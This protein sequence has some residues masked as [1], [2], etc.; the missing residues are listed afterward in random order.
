M[1]AADQRSGPVG[2]RSLTALLL[3]L[4]LCA[5]AGNSLLNRAALAENTID[6]ASFTAIR[7]VS[8]ALLLGLL[9]GWR[10]GRAV[11]PRRDTIVPAVALFLYAVS[12]SFAYV[13]LDAAIGALI[14][15]P[16]GQL[17]LQMIGIVR[18]IY[19]TAI[20][21]AGLLLA[22]AGLAVFLAP[23]DTAPPLA[24]GLIMA[25]AGIS[26]GFYSWAGK[27]AARPALATARNFV[28]AAVLCLLLIPVLGSGEHVQPTG[29]MLAIISGTITSGLGYITWY[30]VLPRLSVSTAAASQLSVPAIAA[31][32]GVLL[33]GEILTTRFFI[34]SAM[35]FAGIGLTMI[36]WSGFKPR[37]QSL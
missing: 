18:G 21:W 33:L 11:L 17:S 8:G 32:G 30:A 10:H 34:G 19:P 13:S 3:V 12:F 7:I 27:G 23:G 20:Q 28:G 6:W 1:S 15:F 4:T 37:Q 31:L 36:K 2:G 35:I 22:I 26:W 25:L 16:A 14:L 9:F 29:V 5:F 24:G